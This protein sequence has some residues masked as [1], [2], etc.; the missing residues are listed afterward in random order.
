MEQKKPSKLVEN[1]RSIDNQDDILKVV[2]P[3]IAQNKYFFKNVDSY[4]LKKQKIV[5]K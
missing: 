3:S 1:A 5:E 2:D 4:N